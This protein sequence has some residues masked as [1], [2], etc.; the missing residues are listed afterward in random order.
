MVIFVYREK[1]ISLNFPIYKGIMRDTLTWLY[2]DAGND[3]V[4]WWHCDM[5][6]WWHSDI[7]TWWHGDMVRWDGKDDRVT[8]IP[9]DTPI[10]ASCGWGRGVKP[11]IIHAIHCPSITC[12]ASL[13]IVTSSSSS[14]STQCILNGGPASRTLAHHWGYTVSTPWA[15]QRGGNRTPV[16][17]VKRTWQW[18]N[19]ECLSQRGERSTH[20]HSLKK[21]S[22]MC[23]PFW[24]MIAKY[25]FF[26]FHIYI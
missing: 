5:V 18:F 20:G 1:A 13:Q 6:W 10:E 4:A 21:E 23:Q 24:I 2:S 25:S 7:M 12:S 11:Y 16:L 17:P 8:T 3:M 22:N 19:A 26:Y 14:N 9:R 15:H